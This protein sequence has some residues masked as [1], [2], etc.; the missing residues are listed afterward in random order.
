MARQADHQ[1][2]KA[3]KSLMFSRQLLRDKLEAS[4][5]CQLSLQMFNRLLSS[6]LL[7]VAVSEGMRFFFL[8]INWL[9]EITSVIFSCRDHNCTPRLPRPMGR[10]IVK[11]KWN[12]DRHREYRRDR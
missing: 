7:A 8:L 10:S 11:F 12:Y 5:P 3:Y 6:L 2:I 4:R 1:V 9:N